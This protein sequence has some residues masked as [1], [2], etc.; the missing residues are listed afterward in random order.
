MFNLVAMIEHIGWSFT[1]GHYVSYILKQ[2]KV[3]QDRWLFLVGYTSDDN[4]MQFI[5]VIPHGSYE[6][7]QN[8]AR[9]FKKL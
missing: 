7:V 6:T 3:V 2:Q 5:Q 4:K 1:Q 9:N 8:Q